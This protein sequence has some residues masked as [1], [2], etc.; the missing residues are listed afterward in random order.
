[1]RR[2][3]SSPNCSMLV[4]GQSGSFHS[5]LAILMNISIRLVHCQLKSP[6]ARSVMATANLSSLS[7]L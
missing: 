5:S 1:M 2:K 4:P 3:R 7:R 6:L